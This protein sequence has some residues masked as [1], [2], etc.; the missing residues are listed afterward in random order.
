MWI[1]DEIVR[2]FSAEVGDFL[3]GPRLCY[4]SFRRLACGL[5]G[6][7]SSRYPPPHAPQ[8]RARSQVQ[9]DKRRARRQ[10]SGD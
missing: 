7:S 2:R 6:L 9:T 4:R 3:I 5:R 1:G 8:L 10:K